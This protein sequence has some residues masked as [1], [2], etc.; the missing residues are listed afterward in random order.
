MT[1]ENKPRILLWDIESSFNAVLSFDLYPERIPHDNILT[2]RHIYCISYRWYGEKQTHTISILDDKKRFKKNQ[3]DDFFVVN[4]FREIMEQANCQV[5]HYGNRFDLPML[6]ARMLINKLKPLPKII[7][8]D[9]K[10]LASKYFKFNSNR[11][12]YLAKLLGH[13]GKLEN[14]KDLWVKCWKGDIKAIQHMARY[15][16]QDIDALYFVFEKLMPYVKNNALNM[17]MFLEGARCPNPTCGSTNIQWRGWN[18]TR[19]NR[20]RRFQCLTC[21]SWSDERRAF[22]KQDKSVPVMK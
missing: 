13:K 22:Q 17:G 6:H 1:K 14:P 7:S 3:H 20:Y 11:L 5:A 9:T 21:G 4:K 15:N 12:D 16:R 2:E 10:A 19:V 8:L 18:Y